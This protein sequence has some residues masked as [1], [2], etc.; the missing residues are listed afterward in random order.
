MDN[1]EL[2]FN[3]RS[4]ALVGS[5]DREGAAGSVALENL[6]LAQDIRRIYPVNPNREKVFDLKCY[7]DV[8]S[9][10]EVPDLTVIITPAETVAN[11]VEECGKVGAICII[12]VSSG[13][14]EIGGKGIARHEKLLKLSRRYHLKIMGPNCM[15]IIRPSVNLNTT[16][17]RKMP[18]P[19]YVTFISQSGAL[20]AGI[21]DWA[22]SKNIGFSAFIS[23]GSMA[24][25]DFADVIDYFGQNPE[26]R[27]IIIYP[28]SIGNARKFSSAARE[29]SR[30]K[31]IITLKPGKSEEAAAVTKTHTGALMVEDL[32]YDAIFRR[33]GIVRVEEMKDL[34]YCASMMNTVRLPKGNKLAIITNGGGP[35]AIT[36]DTLI[37]RSGTLAKL[38]KETVMAMDEILPDTWN[39]SNPVDIGEDADYQRFVKAI[40]IISKDRGVDGLL[41]IYTPQGT[42]DPIELAHAVVGLA[43]KSSKP[44][45][46]AFIGGDDVVGA[47]Q[48]FN[49]NRIPTFEYPED[50][51]RT[52][53]YMYDYARNQEM[54]YETPEESP[55][56]GVNKNHVRAM[57][58]RLLENGITR[59]NPEDTSRLVSTYG[60]PFPAQ[61]FVTNL[62]DA[63]KAALKIGY[64]VALK[65]Y[66]P[67]I[68]HKSDIGG[69]ALDIHSNGD[70]KEA[71]ERVISNVKNGQPNCRIEGV[72]VQKMI[73]NPEYELIIGSKKDPA[74]GSVIMFG[75]GGVEAEYF[76]D[77]AAGLPPLNKI[78]ARRVVEQTRIYDMLRNGFRNKPAVDLRLL[79]NIL[80][81]VSNL[82]VDFPEIKE[83]D[84]NPLV[85]SEGELTS[86]DIRIILD[87]KTPNNNN[88]AYPHLIIMPY[89]AHY[90]QPWIC[91]D[92]RQVLLRPVKPDDE[93]LEKKLFDSLPES[94]IRYRFMHVIKEMSHDMLTRFCNIDYDRE[95][96]IIAEYK[97]D[98]ETYIVGVGTLSIPTGSDSGEF[99]WVVAQEFEGVGLGLK[100]F[101]VIVGI[102]V[103]RNL[104]SLYGIAFNENTRALGLAR[105]VGCRFEEVSPEETRI[106]LNL[107]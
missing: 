102:A 29:F 89:P 15:G 100:L 59:L 79:D 85:V 5:T 47:R 27:S 21:L 49:Q 92:G 4:I 1:M 8:T 2:F 48:I 35:A 12:I 66:S 74:C 57:I 60:I 106:I 77:I 39:G 7:P 22:I 97:D 64:P 63:I 30:S 34:F 14:K 103:E 52:Y 107:G 98:G 24:G 70:L 33:T 94:A 10:P 44:I 84:I 65:I 3:P 76:K 104:K 17:F 67:D 41:V 50:A 96:A 31:P 13:F 105:R 91:K 36:T 69:V 16:F 43:R 26:T 25:V 99:S 90:I 37:S 61:E 19:G 71:Y 62:D 72:V 18:K 11:I 88:S 9:L 54:L 40:G 75:R 46:T 80:I 28:E 68:I 6:L 73:A 87:P 51:V 56:V 42:T 82:I 53:L 93:I 20:G 32:Y 95:M 78:L 86:L 81:K 58:H 38:K 45:L 23:L 83:M 55:I 101:D